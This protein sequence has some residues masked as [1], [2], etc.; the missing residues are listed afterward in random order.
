MDKNILNEAFFWKH[1]ADTL[2]ENSG[3]NKELFYK[4]I[5]PI[6]SI[7]DIENVDKVSKDIVKAARDKTGYVKENFVKILSDFKQAK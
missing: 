3:I 6:K 2:L 5:K 1:L 7:W 4:K